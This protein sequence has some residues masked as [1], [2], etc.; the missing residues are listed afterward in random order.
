ME[1]IR[2][3]GAPAPKNSAIRML[4]LPDTR[5]FTQPTN[6]ASAMRKIAHADAQT[7]AS[8]GSG[9]MVPSME[10]MNS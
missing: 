5:P 1:T 6:E 3:L 7:T 4:V 8:A 10:S 9:A 2:R